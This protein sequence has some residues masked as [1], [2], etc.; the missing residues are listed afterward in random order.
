M[1]HNV[2]EITKVINKVLQEMGAV[3]SQPANTGKEI[4][5]GVSNRHIHLTQ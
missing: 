2:A 4:P 5:I 1:E 3:E